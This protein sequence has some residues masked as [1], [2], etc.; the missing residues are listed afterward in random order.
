MSFNC[1]S[2]HI[3]SSIA[4]C[5]KKMFIGGRSFVH[6]FEFNGAQIKIQ[7]L[8]AVTASTAKAA[9]VVVVLAVAENTTV[10]FT[11]YVF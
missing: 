9:A 11:L 8:V 4:D 6:C 3:S 7:K 1:F 10:N 2:K 5:K